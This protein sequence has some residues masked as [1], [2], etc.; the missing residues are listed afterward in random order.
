MA[1]AGTKRLISANDAKWMQMKT[2][3]FESGA[4][5]WR[6]KFALFRPVNDGHFIGL[7]NRQNDSP[8]ASN[9]A[10]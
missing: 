4:A 10:E 2:E 3:C 7:M 6:L 9:I 5:R 8:H 1:A